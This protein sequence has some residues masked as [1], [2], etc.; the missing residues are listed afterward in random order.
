[1]DGGA[2]ELPP[3]PIG[4]MSRDLVSKRTM[5]HG[6][7]LRSHLVN[8]LPRS[9]RVRGTMD[10][11][12]SLSHCKIVVC[13]FMPLSAST[14]IKADH[15]GLWIFPPTPEIWSGHVLLTESAFDQ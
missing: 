15:G 5:V 10:L 4:S 2:L 7:S 11:L 8:I 12:L 3:S 14:S 13:L 1:M 6:V 9:S